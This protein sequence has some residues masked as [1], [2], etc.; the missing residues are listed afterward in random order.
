[1]FQKRMDAIEHNDNKHLVWIPLGMLILMTL[2]VPIITGA[3]GEIIPNANPEAMVS[4][5]GTILM[6]LNV[7]IS[8]ALISKLGK[9]KMNDLGFESAKAFSKVLIGM[10]SGCIAIS[11]VA[12][13]I[14]TI[15]GVTMSYTFKPENIITILVG[16]VLFAFQGTYEEIVYRGYLLPHFAKKWGIII[17]ILVSSVLFTLL[18]AMNPGMTIMPVVNLMIASVVFSLVY[19]NWGSLWIAGFAHAIWNYSQGLIYGSL[20]SGISVEGSV[21]TSLPIDGKVILSGGNFGFEG[22]IVTSLVGIILIVVLSII[23][24]K[25]TQEMA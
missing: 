6:V 15:G 8:L 10:I 16:L 24:K 4:I 13:I 12:F 11:V 25:K 20:I 23:A 17:A 22:S 3:L 19:Y 5:H 1:M 18:H 14:K 9:M 2:V 7:V 21:M